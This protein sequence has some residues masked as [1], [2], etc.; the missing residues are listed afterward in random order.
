VAWIPE[1]HA[2]V[3][4]NSHSMVLPGAG[5]Y[6]FH[7]RNSAARPG[8]CREGFLVLLLLIIGPAGLC[9]LG[10]CAKKVMRGMTGMT[11]R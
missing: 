11:G 3:G 7:F 10:G 8:S 6:A 1:I 5:K 2:A 9:L 4:F